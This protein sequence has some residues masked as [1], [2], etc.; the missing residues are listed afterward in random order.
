MELYLM[1]LN[2]IPEWLKFALYFRLF[3]PLVVQ[4]LTRVARSSIRSC[5]ASKG[6]SYMEGASWDRK[7]G[8][9]KE[10]KAKELITP[11]P[12]ILFKPFDCPI[13]GQS[14]KSP[15]SHSYLDHLGNQTQGINF[16]ISQLSELL[17]CSHFF[18]FPNDSGIEP[19]HWL[20]WR[21]L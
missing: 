6:C 1:I 3:G 5:A 21:Y 18:R 20:K 16:G 2:P 11:L 13:F 14:E 12:T 8:C 17:F 9:L 4:W 19:V 10:S 15:L 7:N